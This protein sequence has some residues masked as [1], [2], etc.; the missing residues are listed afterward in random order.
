MTEWRQHSV[1][2]AWWGSWTWGCLGSG[3]GLK[4]SSKSKQG[5][6]RVGNIWILVKGAE[7]VKTMARPV[8]FQETRRK[9]SW[10]KWRLWFQPLSLFIYSFLFHS[11]IYSKTVCWVL[12][13]SLCAGIQ[14]WTGLNSAFSVINNVTY[15]AIIWQHGC[16][17]F[18]HVSLILTKKHLYSRQN[19]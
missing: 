14:T 13:K 16:K 15:W 18:I 6:R 2:R 10:L 7:T 11:H 9:L 8:V 4:N 19:V 17:L 3:C 5:T 12:L 1:L